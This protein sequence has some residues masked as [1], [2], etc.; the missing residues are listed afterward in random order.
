MPSHWFINVHRSEGGNIKAC[1][2]H[3]YDDS[4]FQRRIIVFEFP[5]HVVLMGFVPDNLAPFFGVVVALRHDYCN[6]FCPRWA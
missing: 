2:P 4:D 5:R 1:Q 6:L 3:I